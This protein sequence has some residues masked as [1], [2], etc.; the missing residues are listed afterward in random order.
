MTGKEFLLP[1]VSVVPDGLDEGDYLVQNRVDP[2]GVFR[3]GSLG[4][5]CDPV[6]KGSVL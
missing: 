1:R 3:G 5:E 2:G 6:T 4:A